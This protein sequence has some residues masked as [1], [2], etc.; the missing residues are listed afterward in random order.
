MNLLKPLSL[1]ILFW[2][3]ALFSPQTV[4]EP[5]DSPDLEKATALTESVTRLAKEGKINEALLLAK[6]ALEIRERLLPRTDPLVAQSLSYVADLYIAKREHG[7]AKITLQR[8]LQLQQE[9]FGPDDVNLARAHERLGFVYLSEGSL[10]KAEDEYKRVLQLKEKKFGADS[11]EV[12]DPLVGLATVYRA[13]NNFSQGAPLFKRALR[14]YGQHSGVNSRDFDQTSV[15]F[16]CLAHATGNRDA[17]NEL[18]EIWKRF[19]P[20][21]SPPE[22]PYKQMNGKALSLPKPDY[23]EEARV[24]RLSGVVVVRILI[25]ETGR[26][27]SAHDMCQGSPYLTPGALGSASNARF[28]PAIVDGKPAKVD[29]VI[30]YRFVAR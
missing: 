15:G 30:T 11:V 10:S 20:P 8:L 12:A 2:I 24:R 28:A 18:D 1:S 14:I 16:S 17:V 26:V 7:S 19:A 25:D 27:S 13:R 6:Q 29:G 4:Q 5:K 21:G 3:G 23:P 9:R 22:S